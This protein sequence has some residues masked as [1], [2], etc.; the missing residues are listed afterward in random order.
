MACS[1][2]AP[3]IPSTAGRL[4]LDRNR[5]CDRCHRALHRRCISQIHV[6]SP[7][8]ISASGRTTKAVEGDLLP[9]YARILVFDRPCV[10]VADRAFTANVVSVAY[11][12]DH[13]W[14]TLDP[15]FR[16]LR[17]RQIEE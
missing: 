16:W 5:P 7:G 8:W 17:L 9:L 14:G 4:A 1:C 3:V 13:C 11:W 15:A 10:G 6:P 2:V 12:D